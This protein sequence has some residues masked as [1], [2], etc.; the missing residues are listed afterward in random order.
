M[1]TPNNFDTESIP[2]LTLMEAAVCAGIH[3]SAV[4]K[5]KARLKAF[6]RSNIWHVPVE[7]LQTYIREREKRAR[8]VL[9][10]RVTVHANDDSSVDSSREARP[11]FSGQGHDFHSL[12]GDVHK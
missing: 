3:L 2:A 4:Y 5:N 12:D 9:A 7:T 10:R 8:G 1:V 6:K 11:T